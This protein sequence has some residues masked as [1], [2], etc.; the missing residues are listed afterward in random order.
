VRHKNI[1][2]EDVSVI[3][4]GVESILILTPNMF[5]QENREKVT[6][7]KIKYDEYII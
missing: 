4:V 6:G 2:H 1:R 7:D 3:L 5:K